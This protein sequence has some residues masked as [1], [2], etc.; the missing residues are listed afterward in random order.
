VIEQKNMKIRLK[1]LASAYAFNPVGAVHLHPGEDIVG[2]RLVEQ[3]NRFYDVW[4]ITHSY[5]RPSV[6]IHREQG[7]LQGV[8]V[9]YVQLPF[10]LR[11]L[12]YKLEIGQ[13][14]YYY[15]WQIAA[16][17]RAR[18]LHKRIGFDAAQ[19]VTFN[20][21]WIPS[22]IGAH[23][24]VPF[25]WG[26]VGGGQRTPKAFYKDYE[27]T[28]IAADKVRL[29]GQ[30][31]GRHLLLTRHRSVRRARAILVCN[32]E[33]R[34][35]LPQ[36]FQYKVHYFPVNGIAEEDVSGPDDRDS[37]EF[38]VLSAGR[39]IHWKNFSAGLE[40]F[41]VFAADHP[42]G[43]L[44]LVGDGPDRE[45]LESL[46]EK[47]GLMERIRVINWMPR[48]DLFQKMRSSHVFLH[49]ALREGGGA[50]VVEAMACGL[51]VIG[52]NNA[53]PGMHIQTEWGIKIEPQS[54]EQIVKEMAEGLK[55]LHD[56]GDLRRRMGEAALKRAADFYVWDRQGER[57]RDIYEVALEADRVPS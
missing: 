52:L 16:L 3:L 36:R 38:R 30:W 28:G 41:G 7:A 42:G 23:L 33:T 54:P 27:K 21:D 43:R 12:F 44:T 18:K 49:P 26:P 20:N 22:R 55:R 50:V 56:D 1:V 57:L 39:M 48:R 8:Q 31:I 34:E 13:R 5:N 47:L 10:N 9:E 17:H 35:K 15:L 25:I 51:P 14:I 29:F 40:A 53:G 46:A 37:G 11:R 6:E 24:P 2:W 19:H 45:K 32:N 4:V